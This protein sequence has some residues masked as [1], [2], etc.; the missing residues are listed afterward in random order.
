MSKATIFTWSPLV[1]GVVLLVV[2][3]IDM[4]PVR[5]ADFEYT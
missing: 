1:I 2:A 3:K 5:L 4:V